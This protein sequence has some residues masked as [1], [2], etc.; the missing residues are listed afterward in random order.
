[1]PHWRCCPGFQSVRLST[2]KRSSDFFTPLHHGH[3]MD[4]S[5][6]TKGR[7]GCMKG[8]CAAAGVCGRGTPRDPGRRRAEGRA[9]MHMYA[10]CISFPECMQAPRIPKT[11]CNG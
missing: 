8:L 2:R 7:S 11:W 4:R 5:E 10:S 6:E 9:Q 3:G 1:M